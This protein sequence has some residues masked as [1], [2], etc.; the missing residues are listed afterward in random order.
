MFI[1]SILLTLISCSKPDK[2]NPKLIQAA[3]APTVPPYTF[4]ENGQLIGVD[5]EIFNGYC[6]SRGYTCKTKSYDFAGMLGAVSSGQA[7]IAFS[8]ISI[9]DQRRKAMEFS[10]PYAKSSWSLISLTK[11]NIL[12]TDLS[13]L[14]KYSIGFPTGTVFMGY[15]QKTF[16]S[17]G[18]YSVSNVKL[19]PSYGEALT[20]LQNGSLD[21]VFVDDS[22]LTTYIN[23][24]KL[25]I[26]S[27]Y[28][29]PY[30]DQLGFA[31]AKDSSFRD[32]FNKYLAELGSEKINSYLK[33][34]EK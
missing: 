2:N 19:Y 7:D 20:D 29:I 31:F 1:I 25:P 16:D 6:A 10:D 21:L 4:E 34:W 30:A 24:L 22:M 28:E 9:T 8:G 13:Q 26:Q 17:K 14:K 5:L 23:K 11:R 3:I 12:I 27:S 33:K 32:D 15:V 18:Y